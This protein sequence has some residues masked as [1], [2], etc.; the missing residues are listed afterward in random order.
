MDRKFRGQVTTF[1]AFFYLMIMAFDLLR[2][3]SLG[4]DLLMRQLVIT[5]I[6]VV[7]Y[8]AFLW[9]RRGRNKSE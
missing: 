1:A 8:G 7:I 9:V 6:A 3:G 2:G 4:P 5:V